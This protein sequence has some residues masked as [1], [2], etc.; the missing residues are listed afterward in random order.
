MRSLGAQSLDHGE[1]MGQRAV[2]AVD[3]GHYQRI[4]APHPVQDGGELWAGTVGAGGELLEHFLAA[5]DTERIELR[6]QILIVGRDA[7]VAEQGQG[8]PPRFRTAV[9]SH[10]GSTNETVVWKSVRL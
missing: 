3:A 2:K 8:G 5:G 10:N 6:T 1:Q 4:T 9:F 7:S